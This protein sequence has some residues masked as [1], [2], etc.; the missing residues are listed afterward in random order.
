MVMATTFMAP[1]ALKL[2]FGPRDALAP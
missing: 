2:L 1:P